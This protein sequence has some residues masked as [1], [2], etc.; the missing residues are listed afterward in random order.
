M[1]SLRIPTVVLAAVMTV[2]PL[3][4]AQ[5][6]PPEITLPTGDATRIPANASV[7]ITVSTGDVTLRLPGDTQARLD[8]RTNVGS[9]TVNGWPLNATRMNRVGATA[10]GPL[11]DSPTAAIH[12]RV[13]SGDITVTRQ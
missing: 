4:L 1:G 9:I 8:A 3:L 13:D 6:A 12:V 2:T 7:D 5:T 10:N 11:G